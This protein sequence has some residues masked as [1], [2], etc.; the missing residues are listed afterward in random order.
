MTAPKNRPDTQWKSHLRRRYGMTV[1]QY[2]AL[3][4]AQ[5]GRCALC[6][7][8]ERIRRGT[9]RAGGPSTGDPMRLG[10]DHDHETGVVR[11]LLCVDCNTGI[12]KLQDDPELLRRAAAY[13][14]A[15]RG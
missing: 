6:G 3:H 1:E 10:V 12:G 14:E 2:D 15:H 7:R 9:G 11:G 13:I 4:A 5:S 8:P